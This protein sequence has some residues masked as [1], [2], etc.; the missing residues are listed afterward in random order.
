MTELDEY[1]IQHNIHGPALIAKR[2]ETNAY[3]E[4][5]VKKQ[6]VKDSQYAN[7]MAILMT[8]LDDELILM[9]M[10]QQGGDVYNIVKKLISDSYVLILSQ[11]HYLSESM[12]SSTW[13]A[14][15][16]MFIVMS[17]LFFATNY[18]LSTLE[19]QLWNEL[20]R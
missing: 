6:Q 13:M 14:N 18:P 11:K 3:W 15:L 19:N 20:L 16:L 4:S 8:S 12:K 7:A 2:I 5:L 1:C 10:D 17:S 9:Y